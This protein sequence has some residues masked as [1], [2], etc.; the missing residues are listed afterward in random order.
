M[1]N[2]SFEQYVPVH[3]IMGVGKIKELG[4]VV[5]GAGR[6]ALVVIGSNHLRQSGLLEAIQQDFKSSDIKINIFDDAHSNPRA[7]H[8]YAG[9]EIARNVKADVIVGIGGGSAMDTAKAIALG[10]TH[11]QDFWEYRLSG[12]FGIA[13]IN[14]NTLPVITVPTT[15]GTAAEISPAAVITKDGIKE[16]IVSAHMFPRVSVIDPELAVSLPAKAT[17]QVGVD[18]FV[19]A[20]EAYL[21]KNANLMSDVYATQALRLSWGNLRSCVDNGH[22]IEARSRLALSSVL[23][24]YA[25]ISAGVGAI[26]ALAA[27]LSARFNIHHGQAVSLL[28]PSVLEYNLPSCDGR[29]T[30]LLNILGIASDNISEAEPAASLVKHIQGFL[31]SIHL[32]QSRLGQYGVKKA[33]LNAL[34][35]E[36]FNPD[37]TT[38]PRLMEN[39][40]VLNIYESLL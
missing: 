25:I 6:N 38:N 29:L 3:I 32:E 30:E 14:A 40:D 21:S 39:K 23:G 4:K 36:A 15:A 26:H 5:A 8:V 33:D 2:L 7:D 9:I 24:G 37:M 20:L 19:Q 31:N 10:A 16:V 1:S 18:A 13:G 28:L 27:P 35:A 34:A 22:D 11:E 12:K 17:A